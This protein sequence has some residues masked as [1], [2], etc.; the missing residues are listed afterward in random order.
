MLNNVSF[1]SIFKRNYQEKNQV[2]NKEIDKNKSKFKVL[3]EKVK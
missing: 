2:L 3:T 1:F